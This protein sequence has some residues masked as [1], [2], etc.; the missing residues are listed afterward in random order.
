MAAEYGIYDWR[1]LPLRT[2]ATLACGLSENSR[3]VRRLSGAKANTDTLLLAII[4]DGVLGIRWMLS[5][6]GRKGQNR[7]ESILAMVMGTKQESDV[8]AFDSG[9]AFKAARQRIIEGTN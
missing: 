1:A 8:M 3:T 6:D 4:A 9:E 5:D 2:A 7:P